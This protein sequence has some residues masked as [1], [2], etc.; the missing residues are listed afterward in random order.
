MTH[1]T[2]EIQECEECELINQRLATQTRVIL[3]FTLGKQSI[4][5]KIMFIDLLNYFLLKLYCGIFY[6]LFSLGLLFLDNIGTTSKFHVVIVLEV[7]I[8]SFQMMYDLAV[9]EV[10]PLNLEK[11]GVC[12]LPIT[13]T[14]KK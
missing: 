10:G 7:E 5:V 9:C 4:T 6:F 3:L 8:I 12:R 11:W 1:T 2:V 14:I 13:S